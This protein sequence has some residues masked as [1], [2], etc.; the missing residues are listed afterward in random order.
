[1]TG[2]TI[3]IKRG[4]ITLIRIVNVKIFFGE[5]KNFKSVKFFNS[6]ITYKSVFDNNETRAASVTYSDLEGG[7]IQ[8]HKKINPTFQHFHSNL[9]SVGHIG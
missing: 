1:M 7:I 3:S 9:E 2:L 5:R 4:E 6:A 8:I